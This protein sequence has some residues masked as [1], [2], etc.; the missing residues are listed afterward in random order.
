[1]LDM[2][3]IQVYLIATRDFYPNEEI[4]V[5]YGAAYWAIQQGLSVEKAI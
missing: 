4:F 5:A 1:M 2:L 3:M